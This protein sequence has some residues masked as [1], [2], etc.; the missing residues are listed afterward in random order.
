MLA[1]ILDVRVCVCVCVFLCINTFGADK[2]RR[3][4]IPFFVLSSVSKNL[5]LL[6]DVLC[7]PFCSLGCS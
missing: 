5:L 6:F 3:G 4:K 7:R 1:I 2:S